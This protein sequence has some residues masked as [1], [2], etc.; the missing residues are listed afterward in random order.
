MNVDLTSFFAGSTGMAIA[1]I[2]ISYSAKFL[3]NYAVKTAT[4]VEA[5][6]ESIPNKIEAVFHRTMPAPLHAWLVAKCHDT[7]A[8][9]EKWASDP[10]NF[11]DLFNLARG[12][13]H[14]AALALLARV[15][16]VGFW[17]DV[18]L[19]ELPPELKT[20][21]NSVK[22]DEARAMVNASAK[23]EAPVILE[24]HTSEIAP[25]IAASA[26]TVQVRASVIE[27][28]KRTSHPAQDQDEARLKNILADLQAKHASK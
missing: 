7:T 27:T 10:K 11:R 6:A 4:T 28:Q 24:D 13:D 15:Q 17:S 16:T 22:F 9:I 1:G 18:V 25:A 19:A 8:Y 20:L 14:S 12:K 21:V 3:S 5:F 26:S 2:A 23:I